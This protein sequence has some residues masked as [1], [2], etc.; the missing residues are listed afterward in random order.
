MQ[1]VREFFP[2]AN[3]D[4]ADFIL[5]VR[6]AFPFNSEDGL[7]EQLAELKTTW[8]TYPGARLCDFCSNLALVDSCCMCCALAFLPDASRLLAAQA[9]TA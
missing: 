2:D 6:T 8:E 5:W 7:R 3:N 4:E 9:A 1:L